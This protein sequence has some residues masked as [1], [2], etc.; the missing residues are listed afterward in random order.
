MTT[1]DIDAI[2]RKC[3]ELI[4]EYDTGFYSFS[5]LATVAVEQVVKPHMFALL[6]ALEHT[7]RER[8][9]A[10]LHIKLV[11]NS[12]NDRGC[13]LCKDFSECKVDTEDDCL[14]QWRGVG[15]DGDA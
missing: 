14:W 15:G 10:V 7:Q 2:R 9:A 5:T 8:D 1:I 6:N 3:E 12:H 11:L 4:D 13:I